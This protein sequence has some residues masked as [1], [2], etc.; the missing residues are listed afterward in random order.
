VKGPSLR[1]H[2][3]RKRKLV[4]LTFDDGP[5]SYTPDVLR[6]LRRFKVHATFFQI[7]QEVPGGGRKLEREILEQGHELA[8]HTQSHTTYP[9]YEEIAEAKRTIRRFSGFTP[10]L[11][12]PPGGGVNGSVIAAANANGMKT[13]LWDVDP[14]DWRTPG[15]GAIIS[16]VLGNTRKG[17]II[18]LHDGG[19]PRSQTVA[20]LPSILRGLRHRHL[21]PVPV[22]ELLRGRFLFRR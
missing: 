4:G 11:F 14:Q 2:G 22:T 20:A 17:S 18:L 10:C 3:S 13:I 19:G 9:G 15:T 1:S 5:S 7:G 12:R 8:D 21:R 6:I 16:N